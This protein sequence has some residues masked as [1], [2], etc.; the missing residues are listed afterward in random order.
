MMKKLRIL[1]FAAAMLSIFPSSGFTQQ[2]QFAS[3]YATTATLCVNGRGGAESKTT[4]FQ[5]LLPLLSNVRSVTEG[6]QYDTEI[7]AIALAFVNTYV[8][9]SS[10]TLSACAVIADALAEIGQSATDPDQAEQ[11]I[12]IAARVRA[13]SSFNGGIER[14]LASPN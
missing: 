12:A 14:L 13:C 11:I 8:S 4:C 10:P 2:S 6:A 9:L 5:S 1:A 7:G 3:N